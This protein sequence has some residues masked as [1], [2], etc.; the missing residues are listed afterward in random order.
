M[1]DMV[2]EFRN[3]LVVDD[4]PA[5]VRFIEEALH[6]SALNPNVHSVH[7]SSEALDFLAQDSPFEDAPA[8]DFVLLDWYLA[9]TTGEEV[10]TTVERDHER[11]P[12]LVMTGSQSEHD[13]ID[14]TLAK[15]DAVIE[16]PTDPEE[17]IE[18][19]RSVG[20]GR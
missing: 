15:A 11:V 9:E 13:I 8:P 16:K 14:T 2:E 4:N 6:E 20:T 7:T 18:A 17:Y 5:D 10:L 3:L 12:V 1:G 19:I